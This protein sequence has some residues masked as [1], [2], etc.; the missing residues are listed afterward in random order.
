M[1]FKPN[2]DRVLIEADAKP[3]QS[4]GGIILPDTIKEKPLQGTVIAV[5]EG[6]HDNGIFVST[7]LQVGDK[8]VFTKLAG[9]EIVI[10]G[11]VYLVMH[12]K[13]V[14]GCLKAE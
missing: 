2:G 1:T 11:K 5:G 14:L 6:Q 7:T 13:D 10:G 3:T 9:Q 12:E 4:A 8:V